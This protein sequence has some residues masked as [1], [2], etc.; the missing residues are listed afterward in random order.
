MAIDDPRIDDAVSA[1]LGVTAS[2]LIKVDHIGLTVPS[3]S[4]AAGF[5]CNVLGARFLCGG[6]NDVTGIRL[7]QLML[8][9][10][11]IELLQPLR[12][13]SIVSASMSRRGPGFH[14]MTF[15]VN[16]VAQTVSALRA[17]G[18]EPIDTDV[19]LPTWNE[20][21]LSPRATF[22]ALLQFVSTDR[23]WDEPTQ[24]YDLGD[25]LAGDVVWRDYVACL[26][27]G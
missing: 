25:V 4:E 26:R 7:I 24:A 17:D 23:R 11:K 9:G 15:L 16:D 27:H 18:C 6:D 5:F 12:N 3:M 22:G 20:T 21:F 1:P 10:F 2:T 13:D 19:R 14:H 8:P